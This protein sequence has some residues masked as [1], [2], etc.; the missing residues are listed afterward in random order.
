MSTLSQNTHN[1]GVRCNQPVQCCDLPN[2]TYLVFKVTSSVNFWLTCEH[3]QC[4]FLKL[5]ITHMQS[6]LMCFWHTMVVFN[7]WGRPVHLYLEW[8]TPTHPPPHFSA[9]TQGK[10]TSSSEATPHTPTTKAQV[11]AFPSVLSPA[12]QADYFNT[13]LS[14]SC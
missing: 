11:T 1:L 8:T 7:N 12:I 14:Y 2:C 5:F 4:A 6:Y 13:G 10:I 3:C 9:M